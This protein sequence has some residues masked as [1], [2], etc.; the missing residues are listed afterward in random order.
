[1]CGMATPQHQAEAWRE[2]LASKPVVVLDGA[3]GTELQ[4]RGVPTPLPLWTADA[5]VRA[6]DVL[7]QV[8][9]DY[10]AAGADIITANTFRT[11]PY[12]LRKLGHGESDA[13]ELTQK[14]VTLARQA[15]EQ[16]QAGLVAGCIAPLEDCFHPERVPPGDVLLR[17][18]A[19]HARNLK[20]AGADL[21]LVETM[22]T[23]REAH[24]A[25]QVALE[26]GLPVLVS[27]V[28][29]PNGTGDLLSGEDLE[30]AWAHLRA[31]PVAGLLVNCAPTRVV[32]AA[33]ERMQWSDESRPLGAYANFGVENDVDGWTPDTTTPADDYGR[34]AQTWR[35]L[36]ARVIG[37]CCGTTPAHVR[38]IAHATSP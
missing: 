16:A 34:V 8:H 10:L 21:L 29:D 15:C 31:L 12:T 7:R 2:L 22:S 30:V 5:A 4:R 35:G 20:R 13:F 28:L 32:T 37:G 36:G 24:D 23:A 9:C 6:P 14:S 1:M 11:A 26:T 17:E 3:T 18:H 27:L 19:A 38:A 33:L 25:A